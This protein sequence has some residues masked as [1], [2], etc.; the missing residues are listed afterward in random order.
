MHK[1]YIRRIFYPLEK[2]KQQL[3]SGILTGDKFIDMA[4]I[5]SKNKLSVLLEEWS[6][7]S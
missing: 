7:I 4:F 1:L 2:T 3:I 5:I 6:R